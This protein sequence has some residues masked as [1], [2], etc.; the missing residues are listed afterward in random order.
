MYVQQIE[1]DHAAGTCLNEGGISPT[2]GMSLEDVRAIADKEFGQF[3]GD[4]FDPDNESRKIGWK[5]QKPAKYDDVESEEDASFTLETWIILHDKLPEVKYFYT[6]LEDRTDHEGLD[7]HTVVA[8]SETLL[9]DSS[10]GADT[11]TDTDTDSK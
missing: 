6:N 11:D 10:S 3:V 4:I 5:F 7:I 1:F 9:T 2:E 8:E